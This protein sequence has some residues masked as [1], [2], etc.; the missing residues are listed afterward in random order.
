MIKMVSMLSILAI[1]ASICSAL[2]QER[3]WIETPD[4]ENNIVFMEDRWIGIAGRDVEDKDLQDYQLKELSGV[5]VVQVKKNSPASKTDL[6]PGDVILKYE[7]QVV[8]SIKALRRMVE[9]TPVG[10]KVILLVTREGKTRD[11]EIVVAKK[12]WEFEIPAMRSWVP[13]GWKEKPEEN[14]Y[15]DKEN[16]LVLGIEIEDMTSQLRAFFGVQEDTGILITTVREG[17]LAEKSGF[18]TGDVVTK[19]NDEKI[20]DLSQ[21]KNFLCEKDSKEKLVFQVIRNKKELKILLLQK[22]DNPNKF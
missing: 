18:K 21:I 3:Y 13:K 11:V 12:K 7:Q 8:M 14:I 6:Q 19:I 2:E 22:E 16:C 9:E 1:I 20:D 4:T 15:Q 17:S 10:R 5:I